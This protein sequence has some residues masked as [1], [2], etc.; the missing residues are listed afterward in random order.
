MNNYK[1]ISIIIISLVEAVIGMELDLRALGAW[2]AWRA[3]H[4]IFGF[5]NTGTRK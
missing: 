3:S 5:L 1:P 2:A 4:N